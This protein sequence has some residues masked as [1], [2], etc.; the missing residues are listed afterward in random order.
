MQQV[1]QCDLDVVWLRDPF[2]LFAAHPHL[3]AADVLF[4]SEGGHGYTCEQHLF[5]PE[6]VNRCSSS[7]KAATGTAPGCYFA[8]L[9]DSYLL[10]VSC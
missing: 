1:L 6:A 3:A 5:T 8:R 4:Q 2:P 9:V 10:A 7:P